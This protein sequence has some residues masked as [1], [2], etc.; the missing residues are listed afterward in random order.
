MHRTISFS[1][2]L[3]DRAAVLRP[4]LRLR[5]R[6]PHPLLLLTRA[7]VNTAVPFILTSGMPVIAVAS[8]VIFWVSSPG[9]LEFLSFQLRRAETATV[10]FLHASRD[11]SAPWAGTTSRSSIISLHFTLSIIL[12]HISR[13]RSAPCK[14]FGRFPS[15]LLPL[16]KRSPLHL[17]VM[18]SLGFSF[19]LCVGLERRCTFTT[20][21]VYAWGTMYQIL[22]SHVSSLIPV[23]LEVI[24]RC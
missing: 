8:R 4:S 6:R 10:P 2:V 15:I 16:V 12:P 19:L 18:T 13:T 1:G 7:P 17:F 11:N 3:Q 9:G 23:D 22:H 14:V 20:W 24:A 21:F 5:L